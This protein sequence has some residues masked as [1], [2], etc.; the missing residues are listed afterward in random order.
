MIGFAL[1]CLAAGPPGRLALRLYWPAVVW[2]TLAFTAL[3]LLLGAYFRRPA[4]MAIVYSFCLEVV[5]GN[6]PATRKLVLCPGTTGSGAVLCQVGLGPTGLNSTR[7]QPPGE[8]GALA[9]DPRRH[10][11]EPGL[12]IGVGQRDSGMHLG[13]IGF[14]MEQVALLEWPAEARFELA[15]DGRLARPRDAHEHQDRRRSAMGARAVEANDALR[16]GDEY[17]IGAADEQAALD[18]ADDAADAVLEPSRVGN[19]LG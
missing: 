7:I 3:F 16:A 4:V 12:A 11:F 15:G 6:M 10:A 19:G 13:D 1:L 9:V 8:G 14:G 5:L 18:H 2:A 17:R